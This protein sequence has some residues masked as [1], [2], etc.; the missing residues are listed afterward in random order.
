MFCANPPTSL[1]W[2]QG[3]IKHRQI[4]EINVEIC[5]KIAELLNM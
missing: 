5:G 2:N 3:R 4:Y 1:K